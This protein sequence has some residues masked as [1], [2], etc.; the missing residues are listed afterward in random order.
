MGGGFAGGDEGGVDGRGVCGWDVWVCGLG[1]VS[2]SLTFGLGRDVRCSPSVVSFS[3]KN[4]VR[5]S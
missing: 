5:G 1:T 3:F 2:T 4:A